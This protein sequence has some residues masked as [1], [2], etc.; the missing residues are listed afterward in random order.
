MNER[1]NIEY[2]GESHSLYRWSIIL[3]RNYSSLR[4]RYDKGLRG[5]E[6]FADDI[7]VKCKICGKE[8]TAKTKRR[9]LCGKECV[10]INA[11]NNFKNLEERRKEE[12]KQKKEK[13]STITEIAVKAK[14]AGMSYGQY[15]ALM[16]MQK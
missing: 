1:S 12:R 7:A 14:Q 5:E 11:K 9:Q 15:T 13:K 8:F 3:K 6:L 16:Y 10:R 4:D 2:K